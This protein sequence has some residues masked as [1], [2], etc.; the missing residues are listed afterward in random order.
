MNIGVFPKIKFYKDTT[1]ERC[2]DCIYYNKVINKEIK[3]N[4]G[5]YFTTDE[6]CS[7]PDNTITTYEFKSII[8]KHKDISYIY[9]C[10][11]FT[12]IPL[13]IKLLRSFNVSLSN[14]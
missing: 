10:D 1:V 12:K 4:V 2:C 7:H 8:K 11:K 6:F 3:S 9:E 13:I 14:N 5:D